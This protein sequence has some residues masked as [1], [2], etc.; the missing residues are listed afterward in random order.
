ML[1]DGI[2]TGALVRYLRQ[3]PAPSRFLNG[4]EAM[5]KSLQIAIHSLESRLLLSANVSSR[6]TLIVQ[7]TDASDQIELTFSGS[8]IVASVDGVSS[9]FA[10]ASVKRIYVEARN[11]NDVIKN[12]TPRN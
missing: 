12:M 1:P 2:S 4:G 3:Q 9:H 7:G 10:E 8:H 6:G 11:G 5:T